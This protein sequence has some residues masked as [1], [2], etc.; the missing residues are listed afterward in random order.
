MAMVWTHNALTPEE[1]FDNV[2]LIPS[3][4][5][6]S[7]DRPA[8]VQL[9]ENYGFFAVKWEEITLRELDGALLYPGDPPLVPLAATVLRDELILV[10]ECGFVAVTNTTSGEHKAHYARFD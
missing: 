1:I 5:S 3:F 7:D 10:Y 9:E 4:L 2:G 8:M 6:D